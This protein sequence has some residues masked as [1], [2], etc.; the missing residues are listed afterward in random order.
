MQPYGKEVA[1]KIIECRQNTMWR[2]GVNGEHVSDDLLIKD[3]GVFPSDDRT[4]GESEFDACT[5]R[6]ACE[7]SGK[8]GQK[9]REKP[10]LPIPFNEKELAAFF[11]HGWGWYVRDSFGSW[12]EGPN[13][14]AFDTIDHL[15][16]GEVKDAVAG[17]FQAYRAAECVV[18][19]FDNTLA[20][21][22]QQLDS[23]FW[24][25]AASLRT[26]EMRE[27]LH[28][29]HKKANDAEAAWRK[30]MVNQ[31]LAVAQVPEAR[32]MLTTTQAES[33]PAPEVA[34]APASDGPAKRSNRKPS[35]A[36]VAMPYMKALFAVGDY[37]SAAVFYKALMHRAGQSDSPF[38]V[39]NRELY[40]TE[41]G[42]TVSDGSLG[43]AWPEIRAQ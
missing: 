21:E 36:T 16:R 20:C 41:A 33:T 32:P 15:E 27:T 12:D 43:N 31:L 11:L 6:P 13:E 38:K 18:G 39:V 26:A 23:A 24:K 5:W 4:S 30:K 17:A 25:T 8:A 37:K 28:I 19:Q 42:T 40:C 34:V 29:A 22:A 9:L 2:L 10:A 35:W 3:D 1:E 7:L 14:S